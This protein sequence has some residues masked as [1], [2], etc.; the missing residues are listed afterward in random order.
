MGES[1][2]PLFFSS[3]RVSGRP[4][5]P[6]TNL[7]RADREIL[8]CRPELAQSDGMNGADAGGPEAGGPGGGRAEIG[9]GF[10]RRVDELLRDLVDKFDDLDPDECEAETAEGVLKLGFA[11]GSKCI[12]NR[13]SA[14]GQVWLAEGTTAWHFEFDPDTATWLDTKGRGELY[15][16]LAGVLARRLGRPVR[17]V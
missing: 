11:D 15:E 1:R 5:T 3:Y 12:L 4:P 8:A 13:Q 17:L 10:M 14:A 16:V 9:A 2:R 6:S 7:A